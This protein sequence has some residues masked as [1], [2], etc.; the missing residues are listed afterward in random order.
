M[1]INDEALAR[2]L[3]NDYIGNRTETDRRKEARIRLDFYRDRGWSHIND[4]INEIF[5]NAKV[6][7]W[8]K[9]FVRF[10]LWQNS[11]KRIIRETSAV[12][13][14]SAQR[15]IGSGNE[16]YQQLQR[17]MHY[18]RWLRKTNR[19]T[20][21]LNETLVRP[22]VNAH[23]GAAELRVDTP[24]KFWAVAHPDDR[25][26]PVGYVVEQFPGI[27]ADPL[28]P[29]FL[30]IDEETLFLMNKNGHLI[31]GTRKAHG[32][33]RIPAVLVHREP[34]DECLLDRFTGRDLISAH[35]SIAMLIVM[36]LKHQKSGTRMAYVAGDTSSMPTGQPMDEEALLNLPE[37]VTASTLDMGADP[38]NYIT[39]IRE[40]LKQIA[41]NYGI[42]AS[43]YDLS[44]QA[45]SGFEIN[46]KRIGLREVRRDQIIDYRPI[47]RD[48][49]EILALVLKR[50]NHPLKYSMNGWNINFGE[51]EAPTDPLKTLELW[52]K[53]E[54]LDLINRVQMYRNLNPEATMK[55]AVRVID[56]NRDIK[57]E[58][59]RDMQGSNGGLFGPSDSAN[60]PNDDDDEEDG[61]SDITRAA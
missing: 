59:M 28:S 36:M 7:S 45:T 55:E 24:D 58:R 9:Q 15:N 46:L 34:P 54:Q 40:T 29:H 26:T 2:V 42:P 8:R 39:A 31:D 44:Y 35:R 20:N 10:S 49:A 18:D 33:G 30:G 43:V 52:V 61:A 47:E 23:T 53:L 56:A 38:D 37:G 16:K 14:E 27:N 51:L 6:R 17:E 57:I 25:L 3:W 12:Y 4:D 50:A 22:D 19:F 1:R 41:A 48:I 32:F 5:Q 11:T 21:L 13:S 60:Q